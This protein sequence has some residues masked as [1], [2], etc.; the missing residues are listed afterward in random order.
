MRLC[1]SNCKIVDVENE[2]IRDGVDILVENG[3]ILEIGPGL[4][5]DEVFDCNSL[6]VIPG[7]IDPHAHLEVFYTPL[8]ISYQAMLHG[9]TSAITETHEFANIF[10]K[11]GV[12]FLIGL[13]E[14]TPFRVFYT[15]GSITPQNPHVEGD[16]KLPPE[17]VEELMKNEK[18]VGLGE[19]ISWVRV[20]KNDPVMMEKIRI[21]RKFGKTVEGHMAGA[22]GDKIRKLAEAGITSCHESITAE[23]VIEKLEAGVH[24]IIREG[25]IRREM[26]RI[27]PEIAEKKEYFDRIMLSPDWLD[28]R[29]VMKFGYMDHLV[30]RAVEYG[31]DPVTALRMV[32]LNPARYFGLKGLGKIERGYFADII[33]VRSLSNPIPEHVMVNGEFVVRGRKL[34]VKERKMEVPERIRNSV[35]IK[36]DLSPDDFSLNMADG[37]LN[38][39]DI[40]DRTITRGNSI[41]V[42]GELPKNISLVRLIDRW[43]GKMSP[44]GAVKGFSIEG[45]ASTFSQ[46]CHNL[47]VVGYSPQA[48][49]ESANMVVEMKGGFAFVHEGLKMRIEMNVGGIASTKPIP[50]LAE[51]L[52]EFESPLRD[53]TGLESPLLTSGFLTFSSLPFLRMTISGMYDVLKDRIVPIFEK[54]EEN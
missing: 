43:D 22:K 5:G 25:S 29:D 49:A 24:V 37:T 21:A 26:E 39:M 33:F 9:T 32:T 51:N 3:K 6:Y 46:D 7:L 15:V 19:V 11:Y 4:G 50:D 40:V 13:S 53:I 54:K 42:E 23:E 2:T 34:T 36:P 44:F 16:E 31:L 17:D 10:G 38:F 41:K 47:L 12:E 14:L 30:S 52:E 45:F 1:L 28:P 48:M 20:L 27:I 8:T 35:A 18:V